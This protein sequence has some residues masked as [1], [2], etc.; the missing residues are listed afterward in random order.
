ML[1]SGLP[2]L[3]HLLQDTSLDG[4]QVTPHEPHILF[5]RRDCRWRWY[6]WS[7]QTETQW[8][9]GKAMQH[10]KNLQLTSAAWA[11]P[12]LLLQPSNPQAQRL[13]C[14]RLQRFDVFWEMDA[15][16]A[17]RAWGTSMSLT[18]GVAMCRNW[19]KTNQASSRGETEFS[20]GLGIV[21]PTVVLESISLAGWRPSLLGY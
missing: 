19:D 3:P 9:S 7:C 21:R 20:I 16:D 2:L 4:I 17:C 1:R 5:E 10:P 12:V 11:L 6:G 18:A 15:T 14:H 13:E 8:P